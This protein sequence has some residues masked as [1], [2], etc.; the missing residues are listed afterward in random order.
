MKKDKYFF[1]W[2]FAVIVLS[3]LLLLSIYLGLSGW[4]FKNQNSQVT[5]FKLGE[6]LQ[7]ESHKN[8]ANSASLDYSGSFIG[9]EKLP[10]VVSIKNFDEEG[11]SYIRAKAFLS[12][13]LH[14]QKQVFLTTSSNWIYNEQDGYYYFTESLP[15]QN[16]IS[17]CSQIYLDRENDLSSRKSYIITFLV[18]ALSVTEDIQKIWNFNPIE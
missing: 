6:F 4:Y 14:D 8:S 3:V 18:E 7:L 2:L 10:Q 12:S 17:L 11:D 9:G 16:K 5:D 13:S 15:P 1:S